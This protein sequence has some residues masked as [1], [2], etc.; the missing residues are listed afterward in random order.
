M[1]LRELEAFQ[2]VVEAGGVGRAALRLHRAQSSVTARI[3]QFESSLGVALFERDGRTLR[4]TAAGDVLLG[5]ADRL[6][7]LAEEARAAVRLDAVCGRLRLGA[8]ESVAASRLPHPLAEFHRRHPEV[9]VELQTAPSRELIAR[10]QAGALDA[11]IVGDEVDNARFAR[12]P[13]YQEELVLVAA[14]G[15]PLLDDPRRLNGKTLLVFYGQGC[16]Y[17]R[18]LEQWLQT[19]RV[20]PARMLEFASYH[21]ILAAAA[22]G[23]GA[24]LVPRSVLD[25]YP[26]RDA[27][28]LREVPARVARLRTLLAMQRTLHAPALTRLADALRA[29]VARGAA[30]GKRQPLNKG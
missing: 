19:L 10:L 8:M 15:S 1:D 12:V 5:Y 30:A 27:L 17:R 25:I 22:A 2:A 13:L 24:S 4:L 6:L 29:D 11:A 26:Q 20:V 28:S 3:Q 21:A 14:A 16:A 23:V 18:R 7:G 9:M